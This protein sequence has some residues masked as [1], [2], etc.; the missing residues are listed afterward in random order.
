M[1]EKLTLRE[2]ID[3]AKTIDFNNISLENLVKFEDGV[4][5]YENI[6]KP[7]TLTTLKTGIA[8]KYNCFLKERSAIR[9]DVHKIRTGY[10][11]QNWGNSDSTVTAEDKI[12]LTKRGIK[13]NPNYGWKFHLD[14]VPNRDHPITKKVSEFLLDLNIQHKIASGGENGKGMTVYVGSYKDTCDLAHLI[15]EQFGHDIYE[16][17]AYTNQVKEEHAFEPTVYGRFT[18]RQWTDYPWDGIGIGPIYRRASTEGAEFEKAR[19][20]AFD[21]GLIKDERN[22]AFNGRQAK[23]LSDTERDIVWLRHYCSHKLYAEALGEYYCGNNID[24][25][26]D[27]FFKDKLP[28]KGSD[29]RQK[30][31]EVAKVFVEESKT[32]LAP[33]Y[34]TIKIFDWIKSFKD[35][36]IPLNLHETTPTKTTEINPLLMETLQKKK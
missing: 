22:T 24:A 26:E 31:D 32:S 14:V 3:F 35:G 13:W 18:L 21:L 25:F 11:A 9:E 33:H 4:S 15:Q 34:D 5:Q 19:K 7:E 8:N 30:W 2:F 29:K 10:K 36:Y 27:A 12:K 28:P 20:K 6:I 16:P 17:P 23:R 1:T